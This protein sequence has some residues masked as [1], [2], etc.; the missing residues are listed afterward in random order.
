MDLG[1]SGKVAMV[2]G[3]SK[4]LGYAVARA[5]AAEGAQV[6]IASRD[7]DAIHRAAETLSRE[8]RS[9]VLPVAA[10][11]SKADAIER[12]HADTVSRFG[13]VDLLFANTG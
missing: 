5:L 2:G 9:E 1:L 8:G 3:A 6:S 7:R 13:A 11:L 12:W 10:D 4:G